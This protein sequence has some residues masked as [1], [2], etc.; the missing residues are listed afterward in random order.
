MR[1]LILGLFAILVMTS[2]ATVE[3]GHKGVE[4]SWGG[5][6]NL[7]I[8]HPEGMS[9]GAH[10]I[11]DDIVEY[12]VR[13]R[14]MTHRFE[15]NDKNNMVT[16][17]EFALDYRL[18]P[19]KVNILHS[20]IT[21]VETKIIKTLKSAGKEVVPQYSA[22]ELNITKRVEAE[23]MIARVVSD[24]LPEFYVEFKRIQMT[25]VDIPKAVA[26]LAEETAVQLGRN[27]LATKKEAEQVALAKARVAK[28]EGNYNAAIFDAKTKKIMSAPEMLKLKQLEIEQTWANKGVSKYGSNN[29]FGAETRILKGLK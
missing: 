9:T 17:V 8:V 18:N 7:N 14:T 15:F 10:W 19:S 11:W 23:E 3:S 20:Q 2:C 1:K 29:V 21:D 16:E 13:E 12:D 27:D 25:D 5:E 6:T 24:E 26:D 4:V 28:S 22:V